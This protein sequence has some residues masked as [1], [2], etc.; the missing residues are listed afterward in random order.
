[1]NTMMRF[2]TDVQKVK[3]ASEKVLGLLDGLHLDE[4]VLFDIKLCFEEAFINAIKHGNKY[5]TSLAVEVDV[6][7]RPDAFE[8]MVYDQGSGF[9]FDYC[10]DPTQ[11]KNLKRTHGRGIFLIRKLMD[12]VFYDKKYHCLHMIKKLT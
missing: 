12:K 1:M 9:D 4:P 8:I 10:D 5:D 7:I 3:E 11:E 6:S 2:P